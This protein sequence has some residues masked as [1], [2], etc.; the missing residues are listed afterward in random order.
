MNYIS[1]HMSLTEKKTE[2]IREAFTCFNVVLMF[3]EIY[4]KT[5]I[6]NNHTYKINLLPQKF[7]FSVFVSYDIVCYKIK[8]ITRPMSSPLSVLLRTLSY[9]VIYLVK[10]IRLVLVVNIQFIVVDVYA[11]LFRD[12]GRDRDNR[13]RNQG[14]LSC[15]IFRT[16]KKIIIGS[17]R[18]RGLQCFCSKMIK[19]VFLPTKY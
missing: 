16:R 11:R 1:I 19:I 3:V 12:S 18:R 10:I 13:S 5:K 8:D 6:L 9:A 2:Q 14:T 7:L 4:H 17:L 15:D